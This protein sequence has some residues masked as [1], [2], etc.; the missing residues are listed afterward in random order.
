MAGINIDLGPVSALEFG[1]KSVFNKIDTRTPME[2]VQENLTYAVP[3]VAAGFIDTV[4]Q[5]V[6]MLDD[7]SMADTLNEY[8]PK[9]G[10]YYDRNKEWAQ[11]VGDLTGM[12]IPG[13]AGVKL[14]KGG[15]FVHKMITGGK[16][17]KWLDSVFSSGKTTEQLLRNINRYDRLL[18]TKTSNFVDDAYRIKLV[19]QMRRTK[20]ADVLK[21]N[22][23]FELSVLATMNQSDVL[24][25]EEF[26]FVDHVVLNAALPLVLGGAEVLYFNK[27]LRESAL[28]GSEFVS[29]LQNPANIPLNEAISRPGNR[30]ALVTLMAFNSKLFSD[31]KNAG[32]IVDKSPSVVEHANALLQ[33]TN[34]V[35]K[36]ATAKMAQ[37]KLF[38]FNIRTQLSEGQH[39]TVMQA[40]ENNPFA[41]QNVFSIEDMPGHYT[42]FVQ[43]YRAKTQTVNK[44]IEEIAK[45]QAEYTKTS[46]TALLTQIDNLQADVDRLNKSNLYIMETDGTLTPSSERK[47]YFR[48]QN[49]KI[50]KRQSK[51]LGGG[52][53]EAV[54][55]VD[56]V[57]GGP[58]TVIAASEN[59]RLILP[60]VEIAS[61]KIEGYNVVE[62]LQPY[63]VDET[64]SA[65]LMRDMSQDWHFKSG[66][67][68]SQ[69]F[70]TLPEPIFNEIN[71]WTGTASSA[72]IRKWFDEGTV[73]AQLLYDAGEPMRARLME[74]ANSDGTITL[75]R[76]ERKTE[77]AL[78]GEGKND[79]VSMTA[80]RGIAKQ[81][82]SGPNKHIAAYRIP[83]SDVIAIIGGLGDEGE[84]LVKGQRMRSLG[85][86]VGG[87]ETQ[88]DTIS[89]A[90]FEALTA[91]QADAAWATLQHSI[92]NFNWGKT[93][94][95]N[96]FIADDFTRLDAV[97]ELWRRDPDK[98]GQQF[99]LPAHV[100]TIEDLE[101]LSLQKKYVSF[102]RHRDFMKAAHEKKLFDIP[103]NQ[104]MNF[105]DLA[106]KLNLPT[107]PYGLQMHPVVEAFEALYKQGTRDF[108]DINGIANVE[109]F[110][111]F[112]EELV[113]F[114]EVTNYKKIAFNLTGS[115]LTRDKNLKPVTL[116]RDAIDYSQ[117][118]REAVINKQI[119]THQRV[120]N[121]FST[122]KDYG[123]DLVY[124]QWEFLN[125]T[126]AT[127]TAKQVSG[128]IEGTQRGSNVLT[129]QKYSYGNN[130]VMQAVDD[131]MANADR[132]G[133]EEIIARFNQFSD[134][135]NRLNAPIYKGDKEQL[136]LYIHSRRQGWDVLAEPQEFI[137]TDNIT[138][139]GFALD[140]K[141]ALNKKKWQEL[142]GEELVWRDPNE[143]IL[144]PVPSNPGSKYKPLQISKAAFDGANAVNTMGHDI[145]ANT[146]QL[147]RIASRGPTRKK[148]W[149][150]PP[151]NFAKKET[152]MILDQN[153]KLVAVQGGATVREASIKADAFIKNNPDRG[154][155]KVQN[156]TKEQHFEN[157]DK[158][159]FEM[160]DYSDSLAQTGK[161]K[162][163][164]VAQIETG[165]TPI[166]EV[167][168]TLNKQYES[169][170][171]R[172]RMAYFEPQL[173]QAKMYSAA[174]ASTNRAAGNDVWQ[175]YARAVMGAPSLSPKNFVG[176]IYGTIEDQTNTAL[177]FL[178]D[179][180]RVVTSNA[181]TPFRDASLYDKKA[182]N[183]LKQS[184]G[185]HNPFQNLDEYVAATF[186]SR[187][188]IN[189]K[190][191]MAK[192]NQFVTLFALR[193]LET[194]HSVLT[195]TS[196]AATM[197]AVIKG[198]RRLP[199]EADDLYNS[200]IGAWGRTV[201]GDITMFD[202]RR[203]LMTATHDWFNDDSLRGGFK[204]A[205]SKGYIRQE[206]AEIFRTLTAPRQ[207][208]VEGILSKHGHITTWLSD[209]SEDFARG[210]SFA[211]GMSLAKR[212]FKME[213]P[214]DILLFAHRFANDVIGD[215]RPTNRP[216][217]FQG[218]VGMPLGLFQTFSWNY[219][220]RILGYVEN[221]QHRAL[222]VQYATQAT[223]FGG[224]TV[225]GFQQFSD[226]FASNYDGTVNPVDGLRN[227]FGDDVADTLLYGTLSNLPKLFMDDGIALYSRGDINMHRIPGLWSIGDTPAA[228]LIS[229]LWNISSKTL[230]MLKNQ[231]GFSTQRFAELVGQYS[232]NRT[233]RNLIDLY[234]GYDTD[235]LGQVI[236]DDV[237]SDIG[238]MSRVL[239]LETMRS[240]KAKEIAWQNSYAQIEQRE[241]LAQ[242]RTEYRSMTRG[243]SIDD[244]KLQTLIHNYLRYGGN[245]EGI[246]TWMQ[247]NALKATVDKSVLSLQ[248]M[249]TDETRIPETKRLLQL[250]PKMENDPLL[251]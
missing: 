165:D 27:L 102:V 17:V 103:E 241:K 60:K 68:G 227:R 48:D 123:A 229:N 94:T 153:D 142:F 81:F 161:S 57:T 90:S 173:M 141:S 82:G 93:K 79:I 160:I 201:D 72:K 181:D 240:T 75:L 228:K 220:Q 154:L 210:V 138:T 30:D 189:M 1:A 246:G 96:V 209:K 136:N 56:P 115:N 187:M 51:S 26:S 25:P 203:A 133:R 58:Q 238:I 140:P 31:I 49:N 211:T 4:G 24:Y 86:T 15:S 244:E 188:P 127:Q 205:A 177:N 108:T 106:R 52:Y 54:V 218:A 134:V 174:A 77:T 125:N 232:I 225:P 55:P 44:K 9:F 221:K 178:W 230:Q 249:I 162:G 104:K 40:L 147:A 8:L 73:E 84:F 224:Q 11:V 132:Q 109:H 208:Y 35:I 99:K 61:P 199:G 214:N 85:D 21:E 212:A 245:I 19:N 144:M 150:V 175:M 87:V 114:P 110:K 191:G 182:F 100:Q 47:T 29:Q 69:H 130:P 158:A 137:G 239:G 200:R 204:L 167:L 83:V 131:L 235:A 12:F 148:E 151:I 119:V 76:G 243:G 70:K 80:A 20:I 143:N 13:M 156:P 152:V 170:L 33:Q 184:M 50:R 105:T 14:I 18:A 124:K 222:A 111:R 149:W 219:W 250:L 37:D 135:F 28:K 32:D 36:K 23:A 197:P 22:T 195:T 155:F 74:L 194:G 233:T 139:Y 251:Q 198:L 247:D 97:A 2:T 71:A 98:F 216:Q 120:Q 113:S 66:S 164:S 237:Y 128:L 215:Y 41:L 3:A 122:A 248:E 7:K 231:G 157:Y 65:L 91:Y 193:F 38:D 5:S 121:L 202:S 107:D 67:R 92:D 112:M 179:K 159:F 88:V 234:T 16:E 196:L 118:N 217:I 39:Q 242:L 166:R 180:Y 176:R 10:D 89:K 223:V 116:W 59:L 53:F 101:F 63:Q 78:R 207:G 46:D 185:E 146:N 172:S 168:D 42:D 126:A 183:Q 43:R 34:G 129:T 213:N 163:T 171:R 206:V 186:K 145:L 95:V 236:S 45:L 64:F 6:G 117:F 190:H 62:I 226:F 192:L 169:I